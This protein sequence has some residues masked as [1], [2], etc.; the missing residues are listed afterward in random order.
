[1]QVAAD[2]LA[3]VQR[4]HLPVALVPDRAPSSF[5]AFAAS[6]LARPPAGGAAGSH[7]VCAAGWAFVSFTTEEEAALA[8]QQDAI[9]IALSAEGYETDHLKTELASEPE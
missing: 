9:Q 3:L 6:E 5:S 7:S 4:L 2:S 1:M 8:L